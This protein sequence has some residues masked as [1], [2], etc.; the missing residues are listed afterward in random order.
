MFSAII[1]PIV[2]KKIPTTMLIADVRKYS[3]L[4]SRQCFDTSRLAKCGKTT[5]PMDVINSAL[6][7]VGT[8]FP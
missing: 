6:I 7:P 1:T 3:I 2:A 8:L 5:I 4:H